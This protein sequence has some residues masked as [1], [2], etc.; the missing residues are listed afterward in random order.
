M[1]LLFLVWGCNSLHL[2]QF[3]FFHRGS[4]Q[5]LAISICICLSQVL[6]EPLRGQPCQATI[7]TH[8]MASVTVS[9]FGLCTWD[10]FQVGLVTESPFFQSLLHFCPCISFRQEQFW[11][12]KFEGRLVTLTLHWEPCLSIGGALFWFYF[13]TVGHFILIESWESLIS[14][15]SG[16]F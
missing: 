16:T 7:C 6:V 4:V 3:F 2:L 11:V 14:Q 12:K 9:G 5:W 13:P 10:G 8:N 15:V 1:K